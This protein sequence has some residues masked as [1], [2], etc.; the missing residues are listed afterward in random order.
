MVSV[1]ASIQW[2]TSGWRR[3][4]PAPAPT[5]LLQVAID[6]L[7][8]KGTPFATGLAAEIDRGRRRR[9]AERRKDGSDSDMGGKVDSRQMPRMRSSRVCA[10]RWLRDV[11]A[12]PHVHH[13]MCR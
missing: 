1:K 9:G 12:G 6:T 11:L 4:K 7:L 2:L 5:D 10:L 8:T 3:P 13:R